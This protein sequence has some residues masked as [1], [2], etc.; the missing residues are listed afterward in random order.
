MA[1]QNINIGAVPNDGTG[2]T[3]RDAMDKV[4]DN[5]AELYSQGGTTAGD[6]LV[7]RDDV[8]E[9]ST[10]INGLKTPN[11]DAKGSYTVA[12]KARS[13]GVRFEDEPSSKDYTT[14]QIESMIQSG[15]L[16]KFTEGGP[17][18][19]LPS[20]YTSIL[21]YT[22]QSVRMLNPYGENGLTTAEVVKRLIRGQTPTNH[23][24]VAH[25]IFGVEMTA[26]GSGY[27]GP[28]NADFGQKIYVRKSGFSTGNAAVGEIDALQLIV[29]QGGAASDAAGIL[30]NVAGYGTGFYGILEGQTSLIA[31]NAVTRQMQTQVGVIDTVGGA[32][33]FHAVANTGTMDTAFQASVT[34]GAWVNFFTGINGGIKRF[35]VSNGGGVTIRDSSGN[36]KYIDVLNNT[37]RIVNHERN[38][39]LFLIN[40]TGQVNAAGYVG[41]NVEMRVAGSKVVGQRITGFAQMTG[42]SLKTTFASY[43]NPTAA[44]AYNQSQTQSL[45]DNLA[46]TSQRLRAIEDALFSHG[47]IG[48]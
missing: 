39:E 45:M 15:Y 48:A 3:L 16:M 11:D 32:V 7:L 2:D 10:F 38:Q 34:S 12:H 25:G 23:Q 37:F 33:G 27:N 1:Q 44:T 4:N 35:E 30:A 8:D 31:D 36:S 20:A 17:S 41:S 21:E 42:T 43:I 47:L 28:G 26:P 40:N 29:R 13:V 22:G 18:F 9:N 46:L 5:F 14:S 19:T 24:G 6:V